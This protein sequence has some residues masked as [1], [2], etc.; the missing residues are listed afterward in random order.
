MQRI[1]GVKSVGI[2]N[3]SVLTLALAAG[4]ALPVEAQDQQVG[5]V[6]VRVRHLEGAVTVQ[7][8]SAGETS[9]AIPNLPLD[10]GDRVW[11][12]DGRAELTLSDGTTVW[13]DQRTTLDIVALEEASGRSILRLW[14]GSA[15]VWRPVLSALAE[16]RLDSGENVVL[17]RRAGLVRVDIDEERRLWLSVYDGEASLGAGGL[18]ETLAAGEQ[19]YTELG[20][21]PATASLFSTAAVDAFGQWHQQRWSAYAATTQY[22][23]RRDYIPQEVKPYA[24][25]LEAS[26]SWFYHDD[27]DSYAWRPAVSVGWSPYQ[28]GRWV[29]GHGGWTWASSASWGWATSHYGRWHHLPAYGWVWFPGGGYRSSWVSWYVGNGYVGWSPIGYYGRPFISIGLWFGGG[30]GY[31][32]GYHGG[33]HYNYPHYGSGSG[34]SYG[35]GGRAVAGKGYVRGGSAGPSGWTMA[36]AKDFGRGDSVRRAVRRSDMPAGAGQNAVTLN[37]ALRQRNV[38]ALQAGRQVPTRSAATPS[39]NG[40]GNRAATPRGGSRAGTAARPASSAGGRTAV[41]PGR[42]QAGSAPGGGR[43]VSSGA[44][45]GAPVRPS[46]VTTA[47]PRPGGLSGGLSPG[48]SVSSRPGSP[49]GGSVPRPTSAS[50]RPMVGRAPVARPSGGVGRPTITPRSS[51]TR[52]TVGSRPGVSSRP[53]VSPRSTPSR[54]SIGRPS[55]GPRVSAPRGGSSRGSVGRGAA[56]RGSSGRSRGTARRGSSR[57]R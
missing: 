28:R 2:L 43:A 30:Y 46:G 17:M 36:D 18:V 23:A 47:R 31:G 24:A 55:G 56:S 1:D 8:A 37:G 57:R 51:P 45:P 33:H 29:W 50:G 34:N 15:L 6:P 19:S 21:A 13:L 7:R 14:G 39:R 35:N 42:S 49:T 52:S 26:G 4:L 25:E 11:T 22:V 12:E 16:L 41:R 54:S 32:R 20:T 27:F 44:R 9:E 53:Q 5:P 10:A 48:R 40:I 3:L 38:G